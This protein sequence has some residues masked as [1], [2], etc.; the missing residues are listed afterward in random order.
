[1]ELRRALRSAVHVGSFKTGS[2]VLLFLWM[3]WKAA[4][5]MVGLEKEM[6]AD[7]GWNKQY[8]DENRLRFHSLD[9]LD[10]IMDY[11]H[12][13]GAEETTT[14]DDGLYGD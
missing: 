8:G 2:Y 11:A 1:M 14:Y 12:A 4:D 10:R 9:Q 7:V 6:V 13:M 5:E 3:A